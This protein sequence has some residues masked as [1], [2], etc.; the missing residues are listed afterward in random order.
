[1]Q[2]SVLRTPNPHHLILGGG[3]T[4]TISVR[5]P[6]V[7][8]KFIENVSLTQIDFFE[9]WRL[10]GGPPREAQ[11]VFSVDL[12]S[13]GQLDLAKNSRV[14]AG[15]HLNVLDDIDPN[16]NN[17][18][19]AGVLHTSVD[20]KVGCLLRLEPNQEAKVS[21]P[22]TSVLSSCSHPLQLC[23]LTIRSTDEEVAAEVLKLIQKPLKAGS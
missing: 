18:V 5:L 7:V 19:A 23:R 8:T 20:G 13:S 22:V 3:L 11:V 17:I 21:S 1:M 10:I 9:R 16:Q 12:T 15:H 14:V 6:I 2:K 4:R